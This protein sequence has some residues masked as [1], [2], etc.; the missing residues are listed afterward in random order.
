VI[1]IAHRLQTVAYYDKILV[2][3]R[4]EVAEFEEPYLLMQKDG[5]IFKSM[6]V[7]SGAFDDLF[8]LAKDAFELRVHSK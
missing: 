1:C 3:D 4:G 8:L 7:S 2:M 5:S 6:C